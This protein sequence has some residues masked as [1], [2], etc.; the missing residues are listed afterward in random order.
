MVSWVFVGHNADSLMQIA[1][2]FLKDLPKI[3]KQDSPIKWL[4]PVHL[5]RDST[6]SEA[7]AAGKKPMLPLFPLGSQVYLVSEQTCLCC[8]LSLVKSG[9]CI[10]PAPGSRGEKLLSL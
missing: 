6:P 1:L 9:A 2:L 5:M 7:A 8:T 4:D 3:Q 10:C